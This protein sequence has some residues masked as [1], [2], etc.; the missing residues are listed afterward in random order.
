[1]FSGDIEGGLAASQRTEEMADAIDS[2]YFRAY[3]LYLQVYTLLALGR[4]TLEPAEKAL[5]IALR[6]GNDR[7]RAYGLVACAV[8]VAGDDPIRARNLFLEARPLTQRLRLW[9]LYGSAVAY[10]P[11]MQADQDPTMT[12]LREA[13]EVYGSLHS[14]FGVRNVAR[15]WM[16]AF[17]QLGRYKT[18]A[19]IDGATSSGV[20]IWPRRVNSAIEQARAYLEDEAYERGMARGRGYSHDELRRAILPSATRRSPPNRSGGPRRGTRCTCP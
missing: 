8:A 15:S 5:A 13:L 16:P 20:S 14:W 17:A 7:V 6:S 1:M 10:L 3:A 12:G 4:S 19:L 2:D 18:V 9:N 11:L